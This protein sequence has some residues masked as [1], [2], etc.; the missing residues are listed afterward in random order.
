MFKFSNRKRG[1]WRQWEAIWVSGDNICLARDQGCYIWGLEELEWAKCIVT[2]CQL[3]QN[4][5]CKN[6]VHEKDD[7][8]LHLF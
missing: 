2:L 6:L 8:D 3:G 4:K 5:F 7:I 1:S